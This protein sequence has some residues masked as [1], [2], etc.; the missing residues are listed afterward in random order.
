MKFFRASARTA[1]GY[2]RATLLRSRASSL[3]SLL[4]ALLIPIFTFAEEKNSPPNI[5]LILADDLGYSDLGCYGGEIRTPNLD[6][7]AENGLRMTQL[8]NTSRCCSTRASLL[9]G[10]YPHQAGVG[11]MM[12][13]NGL[14]GYRGFLTDRCVTIPSILQAQGYQ[15]LMSGKWHLQG[16][17]NPDCIPTKHGF[18]EF[19]GCFKAYASFY[20]SDIYV[21]LP[22]DRASPPTKTDFYATD[23][24]TDNALT[25][26][27][28]ARKHTA[29]YF[30]YLAYNA[31]HFPL[32][33][34]KEM[35]DKYVPT[36]EKGWDQIREDRYSRMLELG[37]IP[38]EAMLSPRGR[39]TKVPNRNRESDYYNQ[40][41]PA[42]ESLPANRQADLA[43][44]M[45][46]YAAMVEI[47]DRNIGRLIDDLKEANELENTLVV[48]LSDNGACAEWDPFGF[49]NNPYPKNKLY[50]GAH[51]DEI[52]QKGTFHS[53]GTGWANACNT[54]FRLYKHYSHEG[55]ISSP[56]ILHWPDR[57]KKKGTIDRQPAH[58]IDLAAM[59]LEEAHATPP[60]T[61]NGKKILPLSGISL[62]PVMEGEKLKERPL[63]FEHEGNRAVRLGPWK[64]VWT[65]DTQEWELYRIDRD[66]AELNDLASSY[67]K[68]AAA[69]DRSWHKWAAA[70]HVETAQVPQPS[71]GMPT[72]YYLP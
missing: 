15:T 50:E 42:W 20:R 24:I 65:N 21:R 64:T 59:F 26:L 72:I 35:I 12:A 25:F 48:F 13:D 11:A 53:Y 14:P 5:I 40:Q 30:L 38:S 69:M 39:V 16:Q 60:S 1:H 32:Q 2:I 45:A 27:K 46:T 28:Q 58:I 52:G 41:I 56:F 55:G 47:M 36:Y 68:R 3:S 70:N 62:S 4:V 49:D 71:K 9:T 6:G 8:Y 34:P 57:L 10:L 23:A 67:P 43:R 18:D 19:Y 33:A 17:G 61:W 63:F 7:L 66:R 37:L 29:P 54:P 22:E 31:P 51:L 44:R